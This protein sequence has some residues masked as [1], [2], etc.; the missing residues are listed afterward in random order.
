MEGWTIRL[1]ETPQ[2]QYS[3]AFRAAAVV[4]GSEQHH[5]FDRFTNE[6]VFCF[7]DSLLKARQN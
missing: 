7:S 3:S 1:P 2:W 5:R 4:I 6:N